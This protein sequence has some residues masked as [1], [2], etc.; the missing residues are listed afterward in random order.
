MEKI[1]QVLL[2]VCIAISFVACTDLD[3]VNG[4]LDDLEQRVSDIESAVDAL[5]R[6]YAD[7]K[8]ITTVD[9]VTEGAGGWNVEFSD[10]SNIV[11]YNGAYRHLLSL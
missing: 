11:L 4:R 9:A 1:K 5:Q 7:G 6:A 2:S 3:E 10:G 8:I